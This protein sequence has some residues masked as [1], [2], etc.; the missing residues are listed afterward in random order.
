MTQGT[1][2][3]R[4]GEG[5]DPFTGCRLPAEWEAQAC[6]WVSL[7]MN[8]ETWPGCLGLAQRQFEQMLAAMR[9]Y[10]AVRTT[11]SLGIP[12]DDAWIR[13]YGPLF[14]VNR[15]GQLVCHDF[16]FNG[17]GMK[18]GC[19]DRDN[20]VPALMAGHLGVQRQGHAFVLEGGSIDV[21]GAGLAMT[22]QQCL[23]HPNRNPAHSRE[24]IQ[25]VLCHATGA[26]RVVWLEGGIEG[27]DTDG[28]VDDVARFINPHTVVAVRL[29]RH[30]PA[31]EVLEHNR[32]ILQE[33]RGP[34]GQKILVIDLPTPDPL[35]Y[36]YPADAY[37]PA[38][39]RRLPASYANFL[40]S[41]GAVLV[42][43]FG[44]PQ[45][46]QALRTLEQAMPSHAIHPIRAE[47]LVVGLGAVHCLTQQQPATPT[48]PSGVEVDGGSVSP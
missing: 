22:T 24:Q 48:I 15:R 34:S 41:N 14:V 10:V 4:S 31:H 43:T 12:T 6:V 37:G 3:P 7:P 45:D 2:R 27:D 25:Q 21:N 1:N 36:D 26:Q 5:E 17:W 40:I 33:V 18:Y 13:D 20:L 39:T 30:D 19:Y 8:P 16:I 47:H 11:Q 28:H 29:P 42:P 32:R 23:L 9:P 35:F 38:Q 44:Q 46:N